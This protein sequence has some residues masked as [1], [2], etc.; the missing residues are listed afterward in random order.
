MY[1]WLLIIEIIGVIKHWPIESYVQ[2][3][4]EQV[5]FN[6]PYCEWVEIHPILHVVEW[7]TGAVQSPIVCSEENNG[8][9]EHGSGVQTPIYIY[10]NVN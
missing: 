5:V 3:P 8:N 4:N 10:L 9:T 6:K 7:G 2:L 1:I